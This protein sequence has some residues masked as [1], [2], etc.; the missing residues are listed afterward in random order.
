MNCMPETAKNSDDA[1]APAPDVDPCSEGRQAALRCRRCGAQVTTGTTQCARCSRPTARRT[2]RPNRS[3]ISDR[4]GPSSDAVTPPP[5]VIDSS[6]DMRPRKCPSC[7]GRLVGHES[8][9]CPNCRPVEGRKSEQQ[10]THRA[11]ATSSGSAET[12]RDLL[13]AVGY[14]LALGG[15]SAT[16]ASGWWLGVGFVTISYGYALGS[17]GAPLVR[18][19]DGVAVGLVLSLLGATIGANVLARD[20]GYG[21]AALQPFLEVTVQA[22]EREPTELVVRGTVRNTGAA[23]VFGSSIELYVYESSN[24]TLV[25]SETAYPAD[26]IEAWLAPGEEA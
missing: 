10:P 16:V 19:R 5:D 8:E 11:A 21:A 23:A 26:T 17:R 6:G 22:S 9:V 24:G 1:P 13:P 4:T 18:W 20:T 7:G 15:F 2:K 25:A 3:T 14:L 12:K